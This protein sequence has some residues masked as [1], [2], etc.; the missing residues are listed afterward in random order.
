MEK[1]TEEAK[2]VIPQKHHKFWN[3]VYYYQLQDCIST[4]EG[5]IFH[6]NYVPHQSDTFPLNYHSNKCV[7]SQQFPGFAEPFGDVVM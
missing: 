7:D 2:E 6:E 3:I 1:P 5:N 4:S